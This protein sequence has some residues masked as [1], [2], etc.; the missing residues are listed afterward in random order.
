MRNILS[1]HQQHEAEN[2]PYG[3]RLRTSAFYATEFKEGK[4]FRNTFQTLNPKTGGMNK[5]KLGTYSH[6]AYHYL[7][8][9]NGHIEN[10]AIRITCFDEINKACKFFV[11]NWDAIGGLTPEMI[12]ELCAAMFTCARISASFTSAETKP[13]LAI[14]DAPIKKL[15]HGFKTGEN[16]FADVYIDVEEIEKLKLS[17]T[18]EPAVTFTIQKLG[19]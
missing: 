3:F 9:E 18:G 15:L 8:T 6:F 13:M 2:Y 7:N 17:Y 10:G 16:V 1:I 11:E 12:K 5:P 19:A 14:L 4:G